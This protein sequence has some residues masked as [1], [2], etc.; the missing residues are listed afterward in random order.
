[1]ASSIEFVEYVKTQLRD[2]YQITVRKMFG[3]YGVYCDGVF[4]GVVCD[5]N[6]LVKIT[7]AGKKMKDFWTEIPYQGAK[8]MFLIEELEDRE[9]LEE[10]IV[11]T[12]K[13]LSTKEKK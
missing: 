10:L 13:E 1:M 8:P 11:V 12:C 6:F 7:E 5:N 4:F 3:E 9:L 2:C